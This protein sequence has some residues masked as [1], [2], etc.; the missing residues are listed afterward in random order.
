V[1]GTSNSDAKLLPS[2]ITV[3]RTCSYFAK[4]IVIDYIP[5]ATSEGE[6]IQQQQ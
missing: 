4:P 6:K 3:D 5:H 2:K 1:Q